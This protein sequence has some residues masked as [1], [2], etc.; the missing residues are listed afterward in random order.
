MTYTIFNAKR[1]GTVFIPQYRLN[2]EIMLAALLRKRDVRPMSQV[3][4]AR[5]MELV[6]YA[7]NAIAQAVELEEQAQAEPTGKNLARELY[8]AHLQSARA[9]VQA[10]YDEPLAQDGARDWGN[11]KVSAKKERPKARSTI[12]AQ[13]IA[14][15]R[16]YKADHTDFNTFMQAWL[17]EGVL[18]GLRISCAN[19]SVMA[20]EQIYT[21]DDENDDRKPV[22]LRR[23][24]LQRKYWPEA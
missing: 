22:Q 15:M 8:V 1:V 20:E 21:V 5:F 24:T 11:R 2:A 19:P 14:L 18:N 6:R 13:T 23:S 17:R 10:C 4:E 7:Q 16:R 12:K 3:P 9:A